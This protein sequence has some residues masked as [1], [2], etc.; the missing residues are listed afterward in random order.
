[1]VVP[2]FDFWSIFFA[3][4]ID[5]II[6]LIV[7]K[8]FGVKGVTVVI[9]LILS[10]LIPYVSFM[11]YVWSKPPINE[12]ILALGDYI[13]NAM[14]NLVNYTISA[15]L[16]YVITALIFMFSGGRTEKPELQL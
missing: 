14:V 11:F 16:G 12:E 3:V 2:I 6:D 5:V 4:V 7:F 10:F 9:T 13:D 1:M 8:L 15:V